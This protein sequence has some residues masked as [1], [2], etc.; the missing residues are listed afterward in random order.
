MIFTDSAFLTLW[1]KCVAVVANVR[2][3]SKSVRI[4]A[5]PLSWLQS[6]ETNHWHYIT[7][8]S[9]MYV[10]EAGR[11]QDEKGS[12]VDVT[13]M[14]PPVAGTYTF[15]PNHG[16]Y[17][18]LSTGPIGNKLGSMPSMRH[19]GADDTKNSTSPTIAARY[20]N[21]YLEGLLSRDGECIVS[22]EDYKG[23]VA[24]HI[25]PISRLDI[26]EQF[27]VVWPYL[28]PCGLFLS[29]RLHESWERYEWA[30]YPLGDGNLVVH[31]FYPSSD[32]DFAY[33]GK[34]VPRS[35]FR[36]S[37]ANYPSHKCLGW[38]YRQ[39]VLMHLRGIAVREEPNAAVP[40]TIWE[41]RRA[42]WSCDH[43]SGGPPLIFFC[44]SS[45]TYPRF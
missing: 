26:W 4:A 23:C 41:E 30:F 36:G 22:K 19:S 11:L 25:I 6:S 39:C 24:A 43:G 3:E 8:I 38:H 5:L 17:V 35:H 21:N 44:S 42:M 28:S 18:T 14:T 32:T 33:Y 2:D 29:K 13:S 27:D 34:V 20:Q 15:V 7:E 40:E 16:E 31:Y 37:R 9:S 1:G 10:N 45:H 12:W